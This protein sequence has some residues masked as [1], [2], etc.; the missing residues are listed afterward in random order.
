MPVICFFGELGSGVAGDRGRSWGQ[1]LI[2]RIRLSPSYS[3][4]CC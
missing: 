4:H 3:Q 2:P 1:W